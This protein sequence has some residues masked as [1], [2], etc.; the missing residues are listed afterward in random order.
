[1]TNVTSQ[2]EED[3]WLERLVMGARELNG[4]QLGCGLGPDKLGRYQGLS[5]SPSV[6]GRWGASELAGY[7]E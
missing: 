4:S 3:A 7:R 6:Q 1:M 5:Y 2:R